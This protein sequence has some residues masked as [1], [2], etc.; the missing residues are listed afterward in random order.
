[1]GVCLPQ[2]FNPLLVP[3]F[4]CLLLTVSRVYATVPDISGTYTGTLAGTEDQ[5]G[6]F[7]GGP[8]TNGPFSLN[9][10]TITV[11][12][13]L[14]DATTGT[15]AGSGT[16][17]SGAP[18][19]LGGQIDSA[20]NVISG[21]F[22]VQDSDVSTSGSL[23]GSSFSS[24]SFLFVSNNAADVTTIPGE[25][26]CLDID[27]SFTL[28]KIAGGAIVI[29][30][31]ITNSATIT[32]L[33]TLNVQVQSMIGSV[34]GRIGNILR[35]NAMGFRFGETGFMLEGQAN[36]INA[37]DAI[38]VGFGT[39]LGYSYS[40]MEND[41]VSLAFEGSRNTV[42]G[43]IDY[44]PGDNLVIGV[45]F[46]YEFS[47]IDTRANR[48]N[49]QSDGYSVIPY[50]GYLL[51]DVFSI[52]GNIGYSSVEADQF[53]TD[54]GTGARIT[55]NADSD[56]FFGSVNLDGMW[57][58]GDWILGGRFGLLW[59]T[60]TQDDFT[61]S[62][63]TFVS[64]QESKLR[65]YQVGAN[66]AY[67]YGKFEPNLSLTFSRDFQTT[68]IAVTSGP[69]PSNDRD[70]FMLAAGIRYYGNHGLTG[71]LEYS[72]RLDRDNF[73]EDTVN[74]TLRMEF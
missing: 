29:N 39:W 21:A 10:E 38:P 72:K 6:P 68:E 74:L 22:N 24:G 47:D 1:M 3:V 12:I 42:L 51:T 34:G 28:S 13:T 65:Q 8:F 30:P 54:P 35:G 40:D 61:E 36:G 44:F 59:A 49:V 32:N 55:S 73:E 70:D 46:G 69:Q 56:R 14:V 71:N 15:F 23:A 57:I 48:G 37:G 18:I 43:G 19:A 2:R 41:F 45:A 63:G 9:A 50:F 25:E 58:R 26:I 16:D 5:C 20:G 27:V 60:N 17:G 11:S 4:I 31:A 62:N 64:S 52:N 7:P 67:S 66:A 33:Q 53:R